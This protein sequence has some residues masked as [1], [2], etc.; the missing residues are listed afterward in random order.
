[1]F[2][3]LRIY[4]KRKLYTLLLLQDKTIAPVIA[5]KPMHQ[6]TAP[7]AEKTIEVK[8]GMDWDNTDNMM[9]LGLPN[10][11]AS[12]YSR[13][14]IGTYEWALNFRTVESDFPT[15]DPPQLSD[16]Q[17]VDSEFPL[18]VAFP[19]KSDLEWKRPGVRYFLFIVTVTRTQVCFGINRMPYYNLIYKARNNHIPRLQ[20][21]NRTIIICFS[22]FYVLNCI[23]QDR[24]C[25]V[26][27]AVD[28][29][30][31]HLLSTPISSYIP[32]EGGVV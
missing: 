30:F 4:L 13:T 6:Q 2:Q 12:E 32:V 15:F 8:S 1:M 23:L 29:F 16:G 11:D 7:V 27:H 17:Y 3:K 28:F 10:F 25:M 26:S 20:L 24:Y 9:T 14:D 18:E 19:K 21:H 31:S 22:G 5:A